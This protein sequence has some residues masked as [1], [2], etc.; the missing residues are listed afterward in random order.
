M[1]R[2]P[3]IEPGTLGLEGQIAEIQSQPH[4]SVTGGAMPR[5]HADGYEVVPRSYAIHGSTTG[6]FKSAKCRTLRVAS[7]ACLAMA[8]PAI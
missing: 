1:A 5:C 3:G 7:V 6:T 2:P 4:Q 8:M